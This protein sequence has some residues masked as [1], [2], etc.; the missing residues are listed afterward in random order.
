MELYSR[1]CIL[2]EWMSMLLF[3]KYF[4]IK[5]FYSI[6]PSFF[7]FN[8]KKGNSLIDVVFK[9][10]YNF[11]TFF[12]C[13]FNFC[14]KVVYGIFPSFIYSI[15]ILKKATHKITQVVKR[16]WIQCVLNSLISKYIRARSLRKSSQQNTECPLRPPTRYTVPPWQI[17]TVLGVAVSPD[18]FW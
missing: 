17:R 11:C 5:F 12:L 14:N 9:H 2:G 4:A 10:L 1:S 7:I 13:W 3:F 15:L 8:L 16:C 18:C 6:F